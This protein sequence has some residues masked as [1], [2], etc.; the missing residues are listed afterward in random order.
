MK[1]KYFSIF[2]FLFLLICSANAIYAA[3]DDN[4]LELDQSGDI[5]SMDDNVA[6]PVLGDDPANPNDPNTNPDNPNTN[7]DNPDDP[8]TN[9][10]DPGTGGTDNPSTGG[11][12]TGNSSSSSSS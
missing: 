3:S 7:P 12:N 4:I 5:V 10:D 9:P 8:N 2:I 1:L 6:I 11:T